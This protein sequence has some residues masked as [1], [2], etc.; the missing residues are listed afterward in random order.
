MV[1]IPRSL[2]VLLVLGMVTSWLVL[3]FLL[4]R[5][6]AGGPGSLAQ[7]VRAEAPPST[8]P[9]PGPQGAAPSSRE[10]E[11]G[12]PPVPT[13]SPAGQASLP[14]TSPPP[15]PL[16]RF[17]PAEAE[18]VRQYLQSIQE[19]VASTEE[20]GNPSDFATD[21]L[22]QSMLGDTSGFDRL[23]SQAR[24]CQAQLAG[25]RPPASCKEH[26]R[27]LVTQMNSSVA[28]L[29]HLKKALDSSDS[30]ALAGLASQ[31][32]RLQGQMRR[33]QRLGEELR[34]RSTPQV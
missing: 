6:T 18:R 19:I 14:Q 25:I 22:T 1:Q 2:L 17:E 24:A 7:G 29:Q 3:A 33:L 31:G 30:T 11:V 20:V 34:Q 8:S 12:D 28:L 26:H 16:K 15:P 13:R 32:T 27:L 9:P 23:L 10:L 5:M 4:G 21:L